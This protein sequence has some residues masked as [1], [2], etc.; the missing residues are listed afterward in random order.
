MRVVIFKAV[1]VLLFCF[2]LPGATFG[3]VV[4]VGG[5]ASD[6]A[7]DEGRGQLYIANFAGRRIDVMS[8]TDN[9]LRTPIPMT[10]QGESGSIALSPDGRYLLVA[11]Y[12]DCP[13]G[14]AFLSGSASPY[15]TIVDLVANVES[16][17]AIPNSSVPLTVAFGRGQQALVVTSTTLYLADPVARSLQALPTPPLTLTSTPLPVTF[18]TFPPQIV[19]AS[20]TVSGDGQT[21]FVLAQAGQSQ[22]GTSTTTSASSTSGI[23]MLIRYNIPSGSLSAT[24]ITTSPALGPRVISANLDGS[25][26]L[27]GWALLDPNIVL[28]AQFPYVSGALNVG[29]H[30]WDY[31]RNLIYAQV[32]SG[33]SDPPVLNV[34]DTDNLTVRERIQLPENLG[35]RTVFSSDMNTLYAISDSGVTVLPIGAF[36]TA[37]RVATQEEQLLFQSNNCDSSIIRQ[38]LDVI[39]LG[40]GATDFTLSVPSG[41]R[42]ITVSQVSGTTP[43]Q[44]T[45]TVNPQIFQGLTGTSVVPLTIQS[46]GSIGIP[47]TV[48]ILINTK[49][50]DQRGVIHNL[51]GTIVDLVADPFRGLIYVLRQDRNQVIVM[52]GTS[53]SPVAVLRTGNTPTKMTFT[54]DGNYLLVANDNSQIANV[55]DLN[56]LQPVPFIAFPPG[57]YPRSIA[58]AN[59]TMLAVVRNVGTPT[60]LIDQIDF[61]N[62]LVSTPASLGIYINAVPPDSVMT[63]SPSGNSI[64]TAMSDGTELLWDDSYRAFEAS[65]KFST[66]L[67]GA[68]SA[69]SDDVF[70]AGGELFNRS[71][72]PIGPLNGATVTSSV[73]MSG[74]DAITISANSAA[75]AGLVQL[76]TTLNTSVQPIPS[77]EAPVT[78]AILTTAPVGQIGQTIPTFLQSVVPTNSGGVLYLSISGF[79]ELPGN[80]D[81]PVA[82]PYISSLGN[83]ADGGPVAPGSLI[84]IMGSGLS[85]A[86]VTGGSLPLA[87]TLGETCATVNGIALPMIRVSPNEIDA[88]LP[89][90]MAGSANLMINT[91]GGTSAPFSFSAAATAVAVFQNGKAGDFYNLPQIYGSA[92]NQLVDFTN[93]IHPDETL[94]I[95]ATGLGQ[96][97]PAAVTGMA[98]TSNPFEIAMVVPS[99]TLDGTPLAVEFAGLLPGSVGVYQIN[100]AVPHNIKSGAQVPLQVQQ[101][102]YTVRVVNP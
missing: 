7:L 35:G 3:S 83:L 17:L 91:P 93:P 16:V 9:T 26:V 64:F 48:R 84:A 11:N 70:L 5:H 97:S 44:V 58:A 63:A 73:W 37:H 10:T 25:D 50:P 47:S 94:M 52:D 72:V 96:T 101:N 4:V 6:L 54:R 98:P 61:S 31:L 19:Q 92:N 74:T 85:T 82:I 45:V 87:T 78:K 76:V 32:P 66:P 39:D 49:N 8:T 90:E 89:Y 43:A 24:T 41:T 81:Q 62:R 2:P 36:A 14:C 65:R 15:L 88:Q 38:T 42:G 67:G 29:G 30:A 53:F 40:G 80:F 86:A 57:H 69:V 95:F 77:I 46:N 75:A 12:S 59:S 1:V 34:V 55:F 13:G 68:Y 18:G 79:S 22:T 51:A 20:D 23:Q 99:V 28:L 33:P 71:M 56:A 100:V 102:T 60:G 27:A 21:I